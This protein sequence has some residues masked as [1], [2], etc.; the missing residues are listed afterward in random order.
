MVLQKYTLADDFRIKE[1]LEKEHL[2]GLL[3]KLKADLEGE[4]NDTQSKQVELDRL[5]IDFR[6][7]HME[8]QNFIN[9]W[10]E[11][12][13]E[14]KKRDNTINELGEKYAAAKTERSKK[15]NLLVVAQKRF[16]AQHKENVEVE[17]KS[18]LLSRLVSR[19]RNVELTTKT[20]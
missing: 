10:Q 20:Y 12:I 4:V 3:L 11:T 5:A 2:T 14:M 7:L 16:E 8:R 18:D 15:E 17:H 13:E 1:N 9:R 19:K 6:D